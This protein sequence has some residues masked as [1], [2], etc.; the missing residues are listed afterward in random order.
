MCIPPQNGGKNCEGEPVIKRPC[1]NQ[2]C[3]SNNKQ[4]ETNTLK[5][6]IKIMQFS[7]RPQRYTKCVIKESDLMMSNSPKVQDL[8]G[9]QM[10]NSKDIPQIP[11][12]AIMN[13]RTITLFTGVEYETHVMTFN[14]I[15]TNLF[16]IKD[17]TNCF[18]LKSKENTVDLCPFGC[19]NI[20]AAVDEWDN[21]FNL[22]KNQCNNKMDIIIVDTDFD[23]KL[24]NI[25][26]IL[27]NTG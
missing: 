21:D 17:K 22:F 18:K 26:V 13:N 2:P 9:S 24:K 10:I 7:N 23:K 27:Y 11:V 1:N 14:L 20:K 19:D 4:T 5:P 12:R 6:I 15:D 3:P 16:R 8:T 25:M